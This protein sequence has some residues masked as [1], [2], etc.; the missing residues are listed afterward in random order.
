MSGSAERSVTLAIGM[1]LVLVALVVPAQ[2]ARAGGW[3]NSIDPGPPYWAP[4]L[5]V[6]ASADQALFPSLKAAERAV[7]SGAYY[8]YLLRDFDY[9]IVDHATGGDF[10]PGWWKLGGAEPTRLGNVTLRGPDANLVDA[11]AGFTVPDVAPGR[12]ELMFCNE[13]CTRSFADVIPTSVTVIDDKAIADL[14]RR[15]EQ[16]GARGDRLESSLRQKIWRLGKRVDHLAKALKHGEPAPSELPS[17]HAST[18]RRGSAGTPIFLGATGAMAL[19][20]AVILW[21]RRATL[22]G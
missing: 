15:V 20:A 5:H 17:A 9:E 4:G 14:G 8:A 10:R 6:R 22:A 11:T 1:L 18:P 3:W 7:E 16:L 2:P 13:G 19:V 21:R 12:Y